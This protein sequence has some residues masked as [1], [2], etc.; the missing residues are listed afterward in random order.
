M[1]YVQGSELFM[2][3][4]DSNVLTGTD[5]NSIE[6]CVKKLQ[7]DLDILGSWMDINRIN[8]NTSKT[9]LLV[10]GRNS[11]LQKVNIPTHYLATNS[12]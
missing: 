12:E 4:D 3:A 9:K 5:V 11:L 7:D 8:I 10:V 2:L 1:H 6:I